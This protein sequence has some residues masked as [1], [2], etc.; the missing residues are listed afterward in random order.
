VSVCVVPRELKKSI[1]LSP[2]RAVPREESKERPTTH[3]PASAELLTSGKSR[4]QPEPPRRNGNR[5]SRHAGD[6]P[7]GGSASVP[8]GQVARGRR[9]Q[10]P[11]HLLLPLRR[12]APLLAPPLQ[13]AALLPTCPVSLARNLPLRLPESE[14]FLL[15]LPGLVVGGCSR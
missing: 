9:G 13:G 1:F 15:E 6:A 10:L 8:A 4:T 2:A 14:M 7:G 12:G 5:R 3:R 11:H